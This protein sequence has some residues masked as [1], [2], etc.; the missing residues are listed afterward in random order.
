MDIFSTGYLNGVVDSLKRTPAFFLNTFFTQVETSESE[1]VFFDVEKEGEKRRL[2]PYVHPLVEGK[3]VESLGF[4]T[5]SF[6]PAYIKDKRV[7]DSTRPFK[8]MAGE[9]IGTGQLM[10]PGQRQEAAIRRDLRDQTDML[11][12]R[13]EVQAIEALQHGRITVN[14]LMPDDTE[15]EVVIN[16][17]RHADLQIT[18]GAGSQWGDSGVRPMVD[19]E[20]WALDV[21]QKSGSTIR[22]VVLEPSA[23]RVFRDSADLEKKLDLRR[24]QSGQI[25][26]GLIP[27]H[28]QYKGSDGTFDYWVYA[29][30]VYDKAAGGEVPMLDTGRVIGVGD[31]MG[32][33][34]FGAIKD[35]RAGFQAREYFSKSW[36]QE[37]PSV[38][39]L[40]LQSAP[41]MVPYRPNASFS[42]KV[43]AD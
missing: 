28:I 15:K 10:T 43:L 35:E 29:D 19:L 7:F 14:M 33:R 38:R 42:A 41:I 16:F 2:S 22:N 31:I 26:L 27:D 5:R 21:L 18:L 6:R 37:D 17:G 23:W 8:R 25:D 12:R 20:D 40:L 4:E 34:H 24:V 3:V 32:V 30:W 9:Q 36:L 1:T 39:F 13:K 11:T